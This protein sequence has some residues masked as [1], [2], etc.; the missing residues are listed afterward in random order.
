MSSRRP[1]ESSMF[2]RVRPRLIECRRAI[3]RASA[4][5]R[6]TGMSRCVGVIDRAETL[7]QIP[8]VS[9]DLSQRADFSLFPVQNGYYCCPK[10]VR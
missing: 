8:H 3:A 9:A 10:S 7:Q 4:S 6:H 5:L 2:R 1:L